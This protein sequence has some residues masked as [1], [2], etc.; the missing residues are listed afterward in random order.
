[1]QTFVAVV[2]AGSLTSGARAL[3][4]APPTIVR[5]LSLLEEELGVRLLQ[6]TTRR[7]SLTAE[8]RTYLER[9]RQIL[10]DVTELEAS[11]SQDEVHLRGVVRVTA[12]I[13]FG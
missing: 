12:P 3:G 1:M 5:S 2:E 10:Q 6:R 7:M 4:K 9:C 13:S 8:G 11:L